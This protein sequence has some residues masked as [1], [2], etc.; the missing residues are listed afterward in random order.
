MLVTISEYLSISAH[1]SVTC[2]GSNVIGLFWALFIL[3]RRYGKQNTGM[4]I[5]ACMLTYM[6]Y[7]LYMTTRCISS[8]V[9][10]SHSLV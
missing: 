8:A 6:T 7:M 1:H 4:L 5:Y 2:H 10:F 3:Y 9:N